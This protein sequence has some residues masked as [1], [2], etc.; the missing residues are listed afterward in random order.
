MIQEGRARVNHEEPIEYKT[1]GPN[2]IGNV[3]RVLGGTGAVH[4]RYTTTSG[5]KVSNNYINKQI[6]AA[7]RGNFIPDM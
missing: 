7:Q 4:T 2:F 3:P 1:R 5:Y 6:R